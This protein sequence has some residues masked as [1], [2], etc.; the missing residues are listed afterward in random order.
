MLHYIMVNK[1]WHYEDCRHGDI[2]WKYAK[3]TS[4]YWEMLDILNNYSDAEKERD[5]RSADEL[6]ALAISETEREDNYINRLNRSDRAK[7]RVDIVKKIEQYEREGRFDEDVEADPP[8]KVL[9]PEDIDYLRS[10]YTDK[11]KTKLA[12]MIARRFVNSLID[13]KK[14]IIKEIKGIENFK[15]LVGRLVNIN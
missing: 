13:E 1:P 2:F 10:S 11:L 14:M 6:V 4:V 15:K 12:F 3:E 7:D 9:M 8:S 5:Q